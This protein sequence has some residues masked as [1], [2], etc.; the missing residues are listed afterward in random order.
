MKRLSSSSPCKKRRRKS[1]CQ[2]KVQV[3]AQPMTQLPGLCLRPGQ[4]MWVMT[5]S[6]LL[7]LAEAPSQGLQLALVPTAPLP[8][9]PGH[10]LSPTTPRPPVPLTSGG[11]RLVA[12]KPPAVCVPVNVPNQNQPPTCSSISLP[13]TCVL[14]PVPNPISSPAPSWSSAPPVP[15]NVFLPY[16][17]TVRVDPADPPSFRRETLQ[18][19]PSLM[20]FESQEEVRDW[21]S[22]RGGV[23]VSGTDAAL[24]YLPPFV[25]SLSTLSALLRAK[26][27]LTKSSLQLLSEGSKRR[28]PQTKPRRDSS[29]EKTSS[30]PPADLPDSTSD[31]R[32]PEDQPGKPHVTHLTVL[33][34]NRL[35]S[36]H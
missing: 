8:P 3:P 11:Y 30:Q 28:H 18:F 14:Q 13:P 12:P 1:R 24:P 32:P 6:G 17:G 35:I 2:D 34:V 7:Q 31:L 15:P 26:K 9:S 36:T 25:S 21:L 33:V 27:S 22:G 29:T 16:K 23:V 4:S 19:D 20:F 5:P 10:I